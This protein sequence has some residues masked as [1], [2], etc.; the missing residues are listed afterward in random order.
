MAAAPAMA[1]DAPGAPAFKPPVGSELG[2]TGV[3]VGECVCWCY[4][5]EHMG[6]SHA[7]WRP[8]TMSGVGLKE[9]LVCRHTYERVM[10]VQESGVKYTIIQ[11]TTAPGDR[12]GIVEMA[13]K[14]DYVILTLK[15]TTADGLAPS[16]PL[17]LA[18][19]CALSF[20]HS[21]SLIIHLL[22]F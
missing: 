18:R 8:E 7:V 4:I 10:S 16:L 19:A 17:S 12:F 15:A 21:P 1:Q 6:T 3:T 9:I 2:K 5:F 14:G 13:Q 22:V 11:T 20:F